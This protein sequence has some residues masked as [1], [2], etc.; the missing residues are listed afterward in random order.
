MMLGQLIGP[1]AFIGSLL[2]E[3][4]PALMWECRHPQ[5]PTLPM[6]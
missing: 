4:W 3:N 6:I 1:S 5:A 2:D